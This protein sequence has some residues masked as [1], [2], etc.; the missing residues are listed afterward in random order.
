MGERY[1]RPYEVF[2][3]RVIARSSSTS[4]ARLFR[5]LRILHRRQVEA[6]VKLSR[7]FRRKLIERMV[8]AE[9]LTS[10]KPTEFSHESSDAQ[11]S[12]YHQLS[13][14]EESVALKFTEDTSLSPHAIDSEIMASSGLLGAND[15]VELGFDHN[16]GAVDYDDDY[17][18]DYE[19]D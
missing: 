5:Q 4:R 19:E 1:A 13:L 12:I 10:T 15:E 7:T 9:A 6:A 2:L 14:S 8:T 17:E 18:D 3:T 16:E 11:M